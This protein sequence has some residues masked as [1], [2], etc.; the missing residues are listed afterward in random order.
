MNW[1]TWFKVVN[2]GLISCLTFLTPLASSMFAP[3]VPQVMKEFNNNDDLIADFVV[4]VYVLG[5]ALGPMFLAPMSELFGR[6]WIYHATNV[7]FIVFSVLC[8]ESSS[9]SML[10]ACRFFQ[11]LFGAAPIT[12]GAALG[13][14]ALAP[15]LGPVI[16]PVAGG[17]LVAAKGWRWVFW[18]L[19]IVGGALTLLCLTFLRE[20]YAAVILETKAARLRKQTNNS[21]IRSQMDRNLNVKQLFSRAIVRPCRILVFSPIVSALSLYMGVVYGYQYLLFSTFTKAF[22]D[23]YGFSTS[24]VGLT[25]LGLGVG[26][27]IGLA[28][29]SSLL[30]KHL[31]DGSKVTEANPNGK[32][33][34]EYR[35]IP[36][37]WSSISLP[38]GLFL[39]G[40]MDN[41]VPAVF[42]CIMS[43][44]IDAFGVYAASALAA[45]TVVR[46]I[47]GAVLPLAGARMY[48]VLGYGWGNSLLGFIALALI[49]IPI[50]LNRYGETLRKRF[51]ASRI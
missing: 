26:N 16:G 31:R 39:Y 7:G 47:F 13:I 20:T 10:T 43:Y 24:I 48:S 40:W 45:N 2:V 30:D 3:G 18:V 19:A 22:E 38:I 28:V 25:F 6:I 9:V 21:S 14:F 50:L 33:K 32:R 34:P 15:V 49:P 4:S 17:F 35:L 1:P 29:I 51:D 36:L 46:S 44:L 41:A 23:Q 37:G 27:L 42:L 5:F 12:I 8:A 11:G